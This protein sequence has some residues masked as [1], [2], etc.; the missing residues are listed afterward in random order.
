MNVFFSSS[1]LD[2]QVREANFWKTQ[3]VTLAAEFFIELEISIASII[4]SPLA[5]PFV[6]TE[7]NIRRM[8][9]RRFNTWIVYRFPENLD[10]IQI[11]RIYNAR[12]RPEDFLDTLK[13]L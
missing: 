12:M 10:E 9:E 4:K 7:W 8:L 13:M 6:N 1:S 3:E 5:F 11:L 2:D